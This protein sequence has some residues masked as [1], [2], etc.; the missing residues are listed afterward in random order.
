[1]EFNQPNKTLRGLLGVEQTRLEEDK[2]VIRFEKQ[3][4]PY[5]LSLGSAFW[6]LWVKE[7]PGVSLD[8]L[9]VRSIVTVSNGTNVTSKYEG[10]APAVTLRNAARGSAWHYTFLPGLTYFHYATPRRPMDRGASDGSMAH[11]LPTRFDAGV[12]LLIN[13]STRGVQRPV[14]ASDK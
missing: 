11:F 3:D 5:A 8:A 2:N 12:E 7:K 9:G 4:L 1:D 14:V 10:G 13:G 6:T